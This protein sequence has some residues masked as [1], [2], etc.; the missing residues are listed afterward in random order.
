MIKWRSW[1]AA[2]ERLGCLMTRRSLLLL[3]LHHHLLLLLLHHHPHYCR[4]YY[5][6]GEPRWS[7]ESE[8]LVVDSHAKGQVSTR[9]K[10]ARTMVDD[11]QR[12]RKA[13]GEGHQ[14]W[15]P[16]DFE[17][18]LGGLQ[19]CPLG[20]GAIARSHLLL[21]VLLKMLHVVVVVVV[22]AAAAAV[23]AAAAAAVGGVVLVVALAGSLEFL[24]HLLHLL[25]L[26]LP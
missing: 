16:K 20:V 7:A 2:C 25:L 17:S 14:E 15:Q 8:D 11:H 4:Y 19:D 21:K 9:S 3:L 26:A 10:P 13:L 6:Q 23:V 12:R 1:E 22:V 24:L 18:S 5:S